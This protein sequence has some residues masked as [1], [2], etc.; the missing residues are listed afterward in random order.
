[1]I[2]NESL[3]YPERD[4]I[5]KESSLTY[6]NG[7]YVNVV[8]IYTD[9]VGSSKLLA[10]HKI[11]TLARLYR[12][13]IA[14]AIEKSYGSSQYITI[15]GDCVGSVF[16]VTQEKDMDFLLNIALSIDSMQ[17]ELADKYRKQ[18]INFGAGI[19]M[20]YGR[21]LMIKAGLKGTGIND[22][23][24]IGDVV[25]QA[26]HFCNAAGRNGH[27]SIIISDR[28]YNKLNAE[29]QENFSRISVDGLD[30]Y[31]SGKRYRA[32]I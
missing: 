11:P 10:G 1:M 2:I 16:D 15:Q 23:L 30:C 12:E 24:W 32:D 29:N 20:A 3:S 28:V 7:F 25:N 21:A 6:D 9:I 22:I 13:F 26:C 18:S 17:R 27:G 5:P 8:A 19:G 14:K 31:E 4:N